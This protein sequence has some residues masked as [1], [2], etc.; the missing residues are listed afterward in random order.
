MSE[1]IDKLDEVKAPVKGWGKP[2]LAKKF[3]YF[4]NGRSLCGG[5]LYLNKDL[6]N[7]SFNSPD[8][9]KACARKR[10]QIYGKHNDSAHQD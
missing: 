7:E 8:D 6:S 10:E 4:V 3:H 5:W 2:G 1:A 9:C